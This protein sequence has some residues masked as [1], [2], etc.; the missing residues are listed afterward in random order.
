VW[1]RADGCTMSLRWIVGLSLLA[2]VSRLIQP[3]S[4]DFRWLG[5]GS[6]GAWQWRTRLIGLTRRQVTLVV[7]ICDRRYRYA[8]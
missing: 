7:G 6:I 5:L 3:W 8:G 4:S 2:Y 1:R